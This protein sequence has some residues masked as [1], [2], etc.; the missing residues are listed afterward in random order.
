MYKVIAAAAAGVVLA[1]VSFGTAKAQC[2]WDGFATTCVAVP[3]PYYAAPFYWGTPY[4]A[5]NAYDF[6]N[7]RF[8]P[9]WLP[10]YPG[11]RPG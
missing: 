6:Q 5:W 11:P 1:G 4:P 10:S 9:D 3:G 7:Y 8:R 2:V